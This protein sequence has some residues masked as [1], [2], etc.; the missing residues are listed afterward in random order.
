MSLETRVVGALMPGGLLAG[1]WPG[2]EERHA[3]VEMARDVARVLERGGALMAEAPTGV[4]KSG[5]Q[6][7]HG[8]CCT[9]ARVSVDVVA[10]AGMR[11]TCCNN[12]R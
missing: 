4:G 8:W 11:I 9:S 6:H 3:Q 7:G 1:R 5:S 10:G 12:C 2:Y